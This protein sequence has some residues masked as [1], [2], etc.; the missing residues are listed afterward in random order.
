MMLTMG[1]STQATRN[2]DFID[3]H[4]LVSISSAILYSKPPDPNGHETISQLSIHIVARPATRANED[5]NRKHLG[6]KSL[7]TCF[8]GN[9]I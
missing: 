8:G 4:L 5:S 7:G 6:L 1:H 3:L 2:I 9:A